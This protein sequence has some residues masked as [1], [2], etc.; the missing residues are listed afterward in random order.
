MQDSIR[1]SFY[2]HEIRRRRKIDLDENIRSRVKSVL[3]EM[4]ELSR[5]YTPKVKNSGSSQS[6]SLKG[7][8][9]PK[10][11]RTQSV[12]DYMAKSLGRNGHEKT[13]Q[14]AFVNSEDLYLSLDNENVA[15]WK[16]NEILQRIPLINLEN[17]LV[18]LIRGE[19]RASWCLREAAYRILLSDT[20]GNGA[21][22]GTDRWKCASQKEQYQKDIRRRAL[23]VLSLQKFM[24]QVEN[25]T[26]VPQA[27]FVTIRCQSMR[28]LFQ[29][30]IQDLQDSARAVAIK[31]DSLIICAE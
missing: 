24:S 17:I 23:V 28:L 7:L 26:A 16:G 5:G 18:L 3:R 27:G 12:A 30:V 19:P 21:R 29:A 9:L 8:C 13:A 20:A 22:S 1:I 31:A 14:Y 15:A 10:L 25:F 6:C 4:H 2:Y 11:C